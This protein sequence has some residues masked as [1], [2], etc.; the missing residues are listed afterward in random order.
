MTSITPIIGSVLSKRYLRDHLALDPVWSKQQ[1]VN[2]YRK[3]FHVC[4]HES[5]HRGEIAF[6]KSRLPG[7]KWRRIECYSFDMAINTAPPAIRS[8]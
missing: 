2:A 5:N 7:A 4:E 1:S 6:L 3:W 8:A